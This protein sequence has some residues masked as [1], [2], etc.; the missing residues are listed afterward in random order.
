MIFYLVSLVLTFIQSFLLIPAFSGY[1]YVP[2]LVL[3]AIFY[4]LLTLQKPKLLEVILPSFLLDLLYDSLGLNI[5]SKLLFYMLIDFMK[6][7]FI[8]AS[9]GAFLATFLISFLIEH[10]AKYA[11]FRLKYYYPF[12]PLKISLVLLLEFL[13]V[14]AFSKFIITKNAQT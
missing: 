8:V 14:L 13:I 9:K 5:T 11:L 7:R 1:L 10:A 2:D 3:C 12:E 6:S 4:R